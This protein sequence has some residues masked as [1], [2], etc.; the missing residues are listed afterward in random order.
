MGKF[1]VKEVHR[2]FIDR[3]NEADAIPRSRDHTSTG[4]CTAGPNP[5]R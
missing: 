3:A 2:D 5:S 4:S 1:T